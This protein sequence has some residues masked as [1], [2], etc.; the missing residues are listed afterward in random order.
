MQRRRGPRAGVRQHGNAPQYD[1]ESGAKWRPNPTLEPPQA[2]TL[3]RALTARESAGAPSASG[4][5]NHLISRV[6]FAEDGTPVWADTRLPI[7]PGPAQG[8]L[9]AIT[10]RPSASQRAA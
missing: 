9:V 2:A 3:S 1:V 8:T 4:L 7:W 5:I 10:E 6:D